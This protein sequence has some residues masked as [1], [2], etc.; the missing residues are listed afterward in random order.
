MRRMDSAASSRA[1]LLVVCEG[2]RLGG[3]G[4]EVIARR[5]IVNVPGSVAGALHAKGR[6]ARLPLGGE[7]KRAVA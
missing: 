2:L 3:A 1:A 4:Q 6:V 5:T 7:M